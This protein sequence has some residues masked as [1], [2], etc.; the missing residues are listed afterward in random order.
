MIPGIRQINDY[1]TQ[2]CLFI[3]LEHVLRQKVIFK[4]SS[5]VYLYACMLDSICL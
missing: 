4:K 1:I 3:G 5:E 2:A